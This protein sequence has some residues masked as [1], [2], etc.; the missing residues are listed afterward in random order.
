[1]YIICIFSLSSPQQKLHWNQTSSSVPAHPKHSVDL[2]KIP[3]VKIIRHL[4][5]TYSFYSSIRPP[6]TW[7]ILTQKLN[8]EAHKKGQNKNTTMRNKSIYKPIAS[9]PLTGYRN[10]KFAH[11]IIVKVTE[12]SY[13]FLS[14]C[15]SSSKDRRFI[16]V[17]LFE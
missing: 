12:H 5:N 14:T 11:K 6:S 9:Q 7:N 13:P 3:Q 4:E 15:I 2:L 10:W 16:G 17:W 1:M 8:S